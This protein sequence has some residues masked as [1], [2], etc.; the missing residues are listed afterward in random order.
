MKRIVLLAFLALMSVGC[1]S[2]GRMRLI[3]VDLRTP[4][5]MAAG[6]DEACIVYTSTLP[7]TVTPAPTPKG[8]MDSFPFSILFDLFKVAK[9]TFIVGELEWSS[10]E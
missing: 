9:G 6:K 10:K 4:E 3:N 5:Q 8:F 2:N 1:V 7:P